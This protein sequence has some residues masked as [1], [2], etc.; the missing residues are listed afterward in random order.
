MMS[1][2]SRPRHPIGETTLYRDRR[3]A[4]KVLASELVMRER[5]L[6]SSHNGHDAATLA[7]LMDY[8]G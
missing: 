3:E 7:A 4:V 6:S 5:L 8:L 1:W 2:R